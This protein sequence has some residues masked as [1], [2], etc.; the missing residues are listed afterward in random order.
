V[1]VEQESKVAVEVRVDFAQLLLQQVE[2][3]LL[4]LLYL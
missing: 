2:E 1:V 4:N 3:V